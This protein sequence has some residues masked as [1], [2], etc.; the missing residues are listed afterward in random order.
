MA[1]KKSNDNS[2]WISTAC[3][4]CTLNCGVKVQLNEEGSEIVRTKGDDDHPA[5]RGYLCNKASRL[6]FYQ[7]RDDRLL[8]PMK[9][10]ADG[11][12]DPI[13][14]DSAI[15]EIASRLGGIRDEH[16]GD[17]I[18]YYG[19]GG[20]GNHLPGAYGSATLAS[21][22]V[23]YRSNALAQEKTGEFWV[24]DRMAGGYNHADFEHAEVVMFVGKN[25]WQSHGFHRA[26][27]EIR[28][29]AKDPDRTLIVL[30]PKRTQTADLADIHLPVK[31]GRDAWLLAGMVAVIIQ[32]NLQDDAWLAEHTTGFEAVTEVFQNVD[33][34]DCAEKSGIEEAII[35]S[36][37]RTIAKAKSVAVFEDLGTQMNRHSTLVSY[38]QR[39]TWMLNGNFAKPGTAFTPNGLGNIGAGH[40]GGKSPVAGGRIIAGIVPANTIPD[41]VLA[42]HP[43]RYRAMII[44]SANPVHSLPDSPKWRQAMRALECSVVI[45]IAMTET[46]RQADYVL[47]ATTQFEKAE[48]TFFNF[49]FPENYFHMRAPLF[50]PPEGVLD[51]AEIHAR[52]AEALGT[53]PADIIDALNGALAEGGRNVFRELVFAKLSEQPEMA[54]V[55]PAILYRTLGKTLPEGMQNA[56]A[57]W[58]PCHQ[59]AMANRKSVEAAGFSGEGML[60]GEHLF[61]AIIAGPSAVV[62]SN[63]EWSD[64]WQRVPGGSINF[65]LP[66]M[67]EA[68][69]KLNSEEPHETTVAFP[70]LLSAGE[71]RDFTA[72][73]IFRN[74]AWRRKDADG[75]MYINPDDAARLNL[76]DGSNARITS[77][78]GS[79]DAIVEISD[80]MQ[81]GHV[82]IPNGL[83]L[84]Y[85]DERGRLKATGSSPN[86]LTSSHHADEFVGT[87]WH[88]SVPVR[89]EAIG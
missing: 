7:N 22:G 80:R 85:P 21:L 46:A 71:R 36:T 9:R 30:D 66:D 19:G 65:D 72:N 31:V 25:P 32:E 5:S 28:E 45:D 61:D 74:P 33:I 76:G 48:A 3:I 40:E 82:S 27:A 83:G 68:A 16:G 26:R 69:G 6:N 78:R 60:L 49:E 75:A 34:K 14:W 84:D 51:E 17:K 41:E 88:K 53:L 77:E 23:Q 15:E 42:D 70:F 44:E 10:N 59:H 50:T 8:S 79:V 52:I 81:R 89:V 47:P 39:L 37:A 56:A 67:L 12:Y 11:G 1:D 55:A 54:K 38:L 63:E 73:T 87:P 29:M 24:A 43:N 35:R 62:I 86:E 4:L 57:L 18:F 20:Q 64:I 2:E 13:D 58:A